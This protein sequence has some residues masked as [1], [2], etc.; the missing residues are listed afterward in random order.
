MK[1]PRQMLLGLAIS[2]VKL[3]RRMLSCQIQPSGRLGYRPCLTLISHQTWMSVDMHQ[4]WLG[5]LLSDII[6]YTKLCMTGEMLVRVHHQR[7]A[8]SDQQSIPCVRAWQQQPGR[9][10]APPPPDPFSLPEPCN[11]GQSS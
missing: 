9:T 7:G 10:R 3:V 11:Q 6:T 4:L 5:R 2:Q 8:M 1:R